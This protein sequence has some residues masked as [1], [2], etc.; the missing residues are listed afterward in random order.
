MLLGHFRSIGDAVHGAGGSVDE[1]A[2]ALGDR[3]LHHRLEAIVVDG[4]AEAWIE[5]EAGIIGDAGEVD[6]GITALERL[7]E[8]GDVAQVA[9]NHLQLGMLGQAFGA[10]EHDVVDDDLIAGVEELGN[11]DAADITG[12]AGDEDFLEH[13]NLPNGEGQQGSWSL[14]ATRNDAAVVARHQAARR[15]SSG[16]S[17]EKPEALASL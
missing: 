10:E 15:T 14:R 7:G 1:A 16:A 3:G 8:A 9:G 6:D 11:E 13:I 17:R 12:T 4:L 2:D 5:L